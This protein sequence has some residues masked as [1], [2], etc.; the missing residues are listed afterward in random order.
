MRITRFALAVGCQLAC[1]WA[2]SDT[3]NCVDGKECLIDLPGSS[4]GDGTQSYFTLTKRTG[5]KHLLIYLNGGGACWDK[6]TCSGGYVETLTR[7]ETATDWA[8]GTG[9]QNSQDPTNPFAKDYNVITVPYCT[10]DAYTGGATVDYGTSAQ[11]FV[12][13]HQG[14]QNIKLVLSAVKQLYPDPDKVVLLGCSAG[15]IGAY[16]HERNLAD[17]YP[18]AAK[19]VVSDAGTP[20]KPPFVDATKYAAIMKSWGAQANLP[21]TGGQSVS[22]FGALL[23]YNIATYPKIRFGFISSY[24]DQVMTFFAWAL[25][26]ATPLTAVHDLIVDLSDHVLGMSTPNARVFYVNGNEHCQTPFAL[27]SITSV[28]SNLGEWLGDLVDDAA[29]WDNQRPDLQPNH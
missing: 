7:Q 1:A 20:F 3:V 28:R 24:Q 10:G 6:D 14:Y 16:V 17:T 2:F 4:C 5:A 12:V 25:G 8:G 11:P 19:Y 26:A 18:D 15:G 27:N 9:I 22:D 29:A 13:H 23:Q 21:T